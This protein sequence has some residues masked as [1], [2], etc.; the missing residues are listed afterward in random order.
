[1]KLHIATAR[2]IGERCIAWALRN[3][4]ELVSMEECEVF[5]SVLYD[6][7]LPV[8][9][10]AGRRCY[11]FHPG[12][13]PQYRGAGA[14]SWAIIN[15]ERETGV[16]LH[17]IDGDIDHGPILA[18]IRFPIEPAD[19]AESLFEKACDRIFSG[20]Q[21]FL[22]MLVSG[23]IPYEAMPQDESLAR[24]YPRKAL[25]GARDLSRYARAFHFPGK[26]EAY[27]VNAAGE[28]IPITYTP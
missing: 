13:L 9:F 3:G 12:I 16:T 25:E 7:I 2:P 22:S 21:E 4:Y 24:F 26:P 19:T 27:Y 14:Y 6:K 17:E 1:M 8:E 20:F 28:K 23:D 5:I 15:G 10:L 18:A 11:N